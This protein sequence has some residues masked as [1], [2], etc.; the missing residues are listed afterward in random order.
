[1]LINATLQNFLI[2]I[3]VTLILSIMI[4]DDFSYSSILTFLGGLS[5]WPDD[6]LPSSGAAFSTGLS[7]TDTQRQR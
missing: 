2:L 5:N 4:S 1:V 7:G 6:H 3:G